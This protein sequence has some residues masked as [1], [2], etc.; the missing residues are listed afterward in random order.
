LIRGSGTLPL[1]ATIL[2]IEFV[3]PL[4]EQDDDCDGTGEGG[5][6]GEFVL[7]NF[8]LH[9]SSSNFNLSPLSQFW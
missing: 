4:D 2:V 1:L 7:V 8:L 3:E 5:E 6:G 9:F